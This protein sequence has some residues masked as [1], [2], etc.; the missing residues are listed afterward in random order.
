MAFQLLQVWESYSNKS[1][2]QLSMISVALQFAGCLA[3]IF[4]SVKETG[5]LLVIVSYVVASVL[6]G[7]IFLQFFV[8]WDAGKKKKQA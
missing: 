6:N 2:G 5:D 3:R 4:T 8:Y 1:T 7:I